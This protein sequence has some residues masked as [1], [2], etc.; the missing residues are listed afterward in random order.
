MASA[1]SS[2]SPTVPGRTG[3][4][5]GST[6]PCRP[7]GPT[8]RSSPPTTNAAPHLRPGSSTTTLNAATAH[9]EDSHRS[10]DCYQP[11]GPVQLERVH[12]VAELDRAAEGTGRTVAHLDVEVAAR[13]E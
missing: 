11:D 9:S 4:S 2:S 3:R 1:R 10:A 13:G 5:S 6:E 12:G 8:A 7:S